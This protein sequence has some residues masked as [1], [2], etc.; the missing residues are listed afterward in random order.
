MLELL[1]L[2]AARIT[3]GEAT[4]IMLLLLVLWRQRRR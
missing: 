4:A 1:L 2:A 3:P